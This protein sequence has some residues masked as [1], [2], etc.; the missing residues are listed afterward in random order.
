MALLVVGIFSGPVFF[1][2]S[3]GELRSSSGRLPVM[4]QERCFYFGYQLGKYRGPGA[5]LASDETESPKGANEFF[6]ELLAVNY[7][8]CKPVD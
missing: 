3:H 7:L 1:L 6:L 5:K 2:P 8:P 4:D